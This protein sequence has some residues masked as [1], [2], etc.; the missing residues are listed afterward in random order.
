[1][2]EAVRRRVPKDHMVKTDTTEWLLRLVDYLRHYDANPTNYVH[3]TFDHEK[4]KQK[5]KKRVVRR[6]KKV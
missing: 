5:P 4:G 1:M 6:K 2:M 3:P